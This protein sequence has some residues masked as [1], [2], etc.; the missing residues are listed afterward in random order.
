MKTILRKKLIEKRNNLD[1]EFVKSKS[2]IIKNKLFKTELFKKSKKIGL[3]FSK[4]KEVSTIGIIK[5]ILKSN[6]TLFLPKVDGNELKFKEIKKLENLEKGTFGIMEPNENC[7]LIEGNQLDLVVMPCVGIDEEGNRIGVGGGF[8]DNFLTKHKAI[9]TV[10]L[11]YEFQILKKFKT[12]HYDQ[13]INFI[14]TE[15]RIIKT[16]AKKNNYQLLDG[17][18]LAN[19]IL[20]DLKNKIKSKMINAR[21]AVILVGNNPASVLYVKIKEI[22]CKEVGIYFELIR[23]N[24]NISEEKIITKIRE[25]NQNKKITGIMI[26]LPLPNHFDTKKVLGLISPEKD[27]DGL[28]LKSDFIPATPKGI[29][30]LLKEYNI[31]LKYKNVT[32]I[33]D[34][35]IIGRPLAMLMLNKGATV[36]ICNKFT[37]NIELY[38]KKADIIVTG[39]GIPKFIKKEIIKEN[40]IVIDVGITKKGKK[41]FGDVDFDDVKNKTS[42]ITPVPGGVGSMTVAML[43]ENIIIS[44][45]KNRN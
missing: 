8:Y 13:Q 40:A 33:N 39:V 35:R 36:T 19:K 3:Y 22:K 11:A 5:G 1:A 26:Q 34:S 43:I 44:Y 25:L 16:K 41:V 21:L 29:M 42:Y 4:G 6:K 15:K 10:C 9:K 37:E 31:S 32:I 17:K 20:L 38:T 27:V 23:F 30:R 7:L 24:K 28:T 2:E 18:H 14:I 45:E 12:E